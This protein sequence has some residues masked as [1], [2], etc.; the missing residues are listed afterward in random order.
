MPAEVTAYQ[1][2]ITLREVEP[3][4]WRRVLVRS[5]SSLVALHFIVQAVMG[6]DDVHL[7]QF[8]IHGKTYGMYKEGGIVFHDDPWQVRLTNFRLRPGE[9]FRYEYD[10]GD[11]WQH[12]LRLE[13]ILPLEA[14][15]TYPRCIAGEHACPPE[16]CGGPYA[17]KAVCDERWGDEHADDFLTVLTALQRFADGEWTRQDLREDED[18]LEAMIRFEEWEKFNPARFDLK[19]VNQRLMEVAREIQGASDR[20]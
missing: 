15:K 4:V 2:L 12:D 5:D 9:R 14:K 18:F 17:Y 7:H 3:S 1:L 10:F 11:F 16:D 6:W 13:K 19:T 8:V 20:S